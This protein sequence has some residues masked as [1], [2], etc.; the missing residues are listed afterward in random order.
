[1]ITVTNRDNLRLLGS[2][3]AMYEGRD[4][5]AGVSLFWVDAGPGDGPDPHWHPYAETWVVLHGEV[6]IEAGEDRLRARAG[7]VI[8]IP[9]KTVHRFRSCGT[10]NLQMLCI[11]ASPMIIQEFVESAPWPPECGDRPASVRG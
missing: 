3:T 11:H 8:T 7:D 1:M 9:A 2:P 6:R 4:H 10:G 5:G